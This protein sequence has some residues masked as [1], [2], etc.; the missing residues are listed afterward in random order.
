MIRL[1]L[2]FAIVFLMVMQAHADPRWQ[3]HGGGGWRGAGQGGGA[4]WHR[5]VYR[6]GDNGALGGFL[7]GLAGGWLWRQW[8]QPEPQV[9]VVP[10]GPTVEWCVQ[11]Y[12]SS[13]RELIS[14][15]MG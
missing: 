14:A 3:R 9:V 13:T 11:R 15:S 4:G 1:A 12:R 7:G 10:Q 2:I 6:G 5:P 8:S